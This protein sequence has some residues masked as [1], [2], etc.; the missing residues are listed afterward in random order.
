MDCDSISPRKSTGMC[1]G[2]STTALRG[3]STP[4]NSLHSTRNSAEHTVITDER[5]YPNNLCPGRVTVVRIPDPELPEPI[6]RPLAQALH[7]PTF[8]LSDRESLL[9]NRY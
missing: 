7:R 5:Q 2:P 1:V 8:L 3:R 4:H 6:I 9:Y